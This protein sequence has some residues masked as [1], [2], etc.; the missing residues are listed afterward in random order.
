MFC[1]FVGVVKTI[2]AELNINENTDVSINIYPNPAKDLVKLSVVSGQ[3]ST[4]RIYNVLG[5]MVDEIEMNSNEIE[6]NV[7]SYKPGI[8]FINVETSNGNI[9]K[10]MIVE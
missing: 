10:K 4:V 8:Y 9:I 3:Q 6:I 2:D 5:M 7:S 1:I